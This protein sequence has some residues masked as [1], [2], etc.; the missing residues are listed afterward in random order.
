[1]ALTAAIL[2]HDKLPDDRPA[3]AD[4]DVLARTQYLLAKYLFLSKHHDASMAVWDAHVK[5]FSRHIPVSIEAYRWRTE[6]E[7]DS[8]LSSS[9]LA[10]V[11][12]NKDKYRASEHQIERA[13]HMYLQAMKE[14]FLERGDV[15]GGSEGD[16]AEEDWQQV[17]RLWEALQKEEYDYQAKQWRNGQEKKLEWDEQRQRALQQQELRER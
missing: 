6:S 8:R 1:M 7:R 4:K 16:R 14:F 17:Q 2:D 9:I 12:P 13:R 3:S 10:A 5:Q 11:S 15:D